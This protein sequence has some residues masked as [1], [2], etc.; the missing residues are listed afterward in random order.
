MIKNQIE[1]MG[2]EITISSKENDGTTFYVNFNRNP[3]DGN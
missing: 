1:T 2:G 3:T